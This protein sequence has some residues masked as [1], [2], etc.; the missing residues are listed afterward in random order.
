MGR[1]TK[2]ALAATIFGFFAILASSTPL[3]A[4]DAGAESE[5]TAAEE[6]SR[7]PERRVRRLGDVVSEDYQPD[8]A[9]PVPI[10][11]SAEE[12]L[13]PRL[14]DPALD[15]RLQ[16]ALSALS[17]RPDDPAA[18]NQL[19]RA[20]D[21][22]L[23]SALTMIDSGQT[24]Q[25]TSMLNAIRQID[26]NK[27]GLGNAWERLADAERSSENYADPALSGEKLGRV[28]SNTPFSLPNA[29]Q[30]ARLDQLIS[31]VAARPGYQPAL[32]E[33]NGLLTDLLGQA[34]VA[35]DNGDFKTAEQIQQ[36]VRSVN[37]R[38][39]GLSQS[40]ARLAR[41]REVQGWLDQAAAA[42]EAGRLVEPL[43]Q[44]AYYFYRKVLTMD[45]ANLPAQAGL[46]EIQQVMVGYAIDAAQ[47]LDFELSEAWLTEAEAIREDQ[48]LVLAGR[49]DIESFRTGKADAIE[50]EISS[51]LRAGDL[52]LAE[53]KLIDLIALGGFEDRVQDLRER[54][55]REESYGAFEPG[56]ILR[57]PFAS[58]A[59]TAPAVVVISSGS[60]LMG[61]PSD[62][63]D[64]SDN[65]SP[66][67]RVTF[68][69][70]FA[71]GLREVTVGEFAA[72][73]A[74][75]GYRTEA[76]LVGNGSVW[77][78][79]LGQLAEREGVTW[80]M[81]YKGEEAADELPVLHLAWAD[82]AAYTA[83][84]AEA[85]GLPYRLPSEAEFEYALRA[86]TRSTHWWGENRPDEL[87]ENL[88]GD[89]DE[90]V[91]GRNFNT[92]F[93]RYNDGHFG[94]APVGSYQT[95]AFGLFDMA[96]NVSE[97][98]QD[99]WHSSY[100]RAPADGSAW[101]NPGCSRRV[102]RGGYWASAP[103]QNRSA[104]RLSAP[105]DLTTPQVGFRI[106]RDLF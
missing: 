44:S 42:R 15:R 97:W 29:A 16:A 8:L 28:T 30:A 93:R 19:N 58:G 74:A 22:A 46:E 41:S 56:Q 73:V 23:A 63:S 62:D 64:R 76:E 40:R 43:L 94:P 25:A 90:S 9:I 80:R 33:L 99:C 102:V 61:S 59:G 72:F 83:W 14:D 51:A 45:P 54:M 38:K 4:Q 32:N 52:E 65:E 37:P 89:Q 10:A 11:P 105:A 55:V 103:R 70:G 91:S 50:A 24:E 101:V 35:M 75:T 47:N 34:N 26:P 7:N 36:V 3:M 98:M 66:M 12:A 27:R 39:S 5:D 48:S 106:A 96:G 2:A 69:R 71:L 79:E 21:A 78:D 84:L 57:D 53:F 100:A 104:S 82:A 85:T 31:M 13:G 92:A 68:E 60:F 20:L 77:D 86:G 18:L 17:S 1:L 6:A 67:H 81:D 49:A 95:N 87:V 88:A